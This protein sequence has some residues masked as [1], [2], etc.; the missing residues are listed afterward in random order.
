MTCLGGQ[1]FFDVRIVCHEREKNRFIIVK[2]Y[3]KQYLHGNKILVLYKK[4]DNIS[5]NY[6]QSGES[7]ELKAGLFKYECLIFRPNL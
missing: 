4:T 5:Y 3:K 1:L 2:K 6:G 7:E